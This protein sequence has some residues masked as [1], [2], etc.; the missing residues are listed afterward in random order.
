MTKPGGAPGMYGSIPGWWAD[1]A[2]ERY[3]AMRKIANQF[4]AENNRETID[5][6]VFPESFEVGEVTEVLGRHRK[7]R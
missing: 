6:T 4:D 5:P 3:T 2:S 1:W 7:E